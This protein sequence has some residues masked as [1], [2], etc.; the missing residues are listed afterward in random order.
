MYNASAGPESHGEYTSDSEIQKVEEWIY[1]DMG[2]RAQKKVFEQ[3]MK[4]LETR[5]PGLGKEVSV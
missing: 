1:S 2:K 3:T 4:V 5:K